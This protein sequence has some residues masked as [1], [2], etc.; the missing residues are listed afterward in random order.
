M[1]SPPETNNMNIRPL[2]YRDLDAIANLATNDQGWENPHD[3][4]FFIQELQNFKQWYAPLKI[5]TLFPNPCQYLFAVRVAQAEQKLRGMI[6]VS[7]FN[8]T[9]STWKVERILVDEN[10]LLTEIGTQ[11]LRNCLEQ[12][13]E[14]RTWLLEVNIN[15]K[16]A[17]AL[18]RQNGFQPLAELT[19]WQINPETLQKLRQ[20]EASLP[21]LLPVSN[22]D[23]QLLYQLDTVAMPPLVRQV[24]DRHLHDFQTSFVNGLFHGVIDWVNQ[25]KVVSAYVFEPQRKAAI[26]YFK[27]ELNCNGMQPHQAEL[28]VHPAYTWLYPELM[29]EMA[30]I[31]K[32][33]P[34]QGLKIASTDYQ[35]EREAFLQQVEAERVESTLLM[36]RSVWHKLKEAKPLS[37]E[38]LQLAEMLQSLQPS[39]KPVPS[40]LKWENYFNSQDLPSKSDHNEVRNNEH[41]N[42][43]Q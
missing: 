15:N 35:P 37:L 9:R 3:Y 18:Y 7:P 17:L 13:W 26:G 30:Q 12:I 28:K 41:L 24:F 2:Q 10:C 14:A 33:Y 29:V 23:A 16:S 20:R 34:L 31:T 42:S 27:L 38:T 25:T 32:D 1:I 36:S 21:N 19:Y 43:E 6:Q 40:R 22:A 5:L 4:N 39:R 11:L 8:Q